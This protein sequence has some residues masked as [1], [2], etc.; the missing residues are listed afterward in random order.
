MLEG[1]GFVASRIVRKS[2]GGL[3]VA[4]E[5]WAEP[6]TATLSV[7]EDENRRWAAL[8]FGS[9]HLFEISEDEMA[10]LARRGHAVTPVTSLLAIEP[11]V[12]PSTEGLEHGGLGLT[13]SGNGGGGRGVG[14]G[15]GQVGRARFD[16]R[17]F[18]VEALAS[19]WKRCGGKG[20]AALVIET[21]LREVAEIRE[22]TGDGEGPR[23]CLS[24]AAWALDLPDGFRTAHQEWSVTLPTP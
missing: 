14:I 22:V 1:E 18:F 13:G 2:L 7:S 5:L 6:I 23:R 12:R 11:G 3:R 20:E 9:E 15:L 24:E 17:R 10:G 21:T 16:G 4:G 19:Q 8:V